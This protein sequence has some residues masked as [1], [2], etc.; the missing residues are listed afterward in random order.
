MTT[1]T[2]TASRLNLRSAPDGDV[3]G[4]I[5]SGATLQIIGE[6]GD[7]LD[8]EFEGKRGVVSAR[9][10]SRAAPQAPQPIPAAAK[11][12][13][14]RI[15]GGNVLGPGDITFARTFK[16]GVFTSGKTTLSDFLAGEPTFDTVSPSL[17]RV[18]NAVSA[19]EG[20]LEAINTWDNAFLTFGAVQWTVGSGTAAGEL[21]ALLQR[22]KQGAADVFTEYFGQYGLDVGPIATGP[23]VVPTGSFL[24]DGRS[25]ATPADKER[26]RN[27]DWAYRFW[28]AGHDRTVRRIQIEHAMSRLDTFYREPKKAIRGRLVA[29]YVS[30]E[31]GVA[32]LLD[33]HVNRPGHVPA[34]LAKAV[35][36][37][38][39]HTDVAHPESWTDHEEREL[40]VL[41]LEQR[42]MTNMTDSDKRADSI[43][44]AAAQGVIADRRGSFIARREE[45]VT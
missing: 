38:E 17:V 27:V 23:G 31:Y 7:W 11:A 19:N 3:I 21:A 13:E 20:R 33:Q 16:L 34:T 30:S 12:G 24:L 40:L 43:K 45:V 15:V 6:R 39:Q 36:E 22:I 29:D 8:V 26:L 37:L 35:A 41:Y 32:L 28:R 5:P 25:L 4:T 42:A 18:M 14:V 9:F 1:G 2:V 10:V 44:R